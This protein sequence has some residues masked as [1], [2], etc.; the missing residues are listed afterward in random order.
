M[1]VDPIS[2]YLGNKGRVDSNSNTHIRG[3]LEPLKR[4]A[5]AHRVA[6]VCVT[7]LIKAGGREAIGSVNGSV[8]FVAAAR[9]VLIVSK[10][11]EEV[12]DEDG[13]TTKAETGRRFVAVAQ[14]NIGPDGADQTMVY[15]VATRDVGHGIFAPF[16]DWD[17]KISKSADE[18][19]GYREGA[20]PG[21]K[22]SK[23]ERAIALLR[24][25]LRS[26]PLEK[27]ELVQLAEAEGIG[28]DTLENAKDMLGVKSEKMP[29]QGGKWRWSLPGRQE[30]MPF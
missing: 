12:A 15:E 24:R 8:A 2:A 26:G 5:E 3:V 14:N 25:T 4:L 29:G 22:P 16:V 10:E 13:K 21:P 23:K 20:R 17:E 7:H 18:A 30:E 28:P 27:T 9:T 6:V 11:I 19:I 1:I